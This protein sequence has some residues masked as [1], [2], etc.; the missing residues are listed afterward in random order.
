MGGAAEEIAQPVESRRFVLVGVATVA[1]MSVW[2]AWANVTADRL[3]Q[4]SAA[5]VS[6]PETIGPWSRSDE[7][8]MTSWKPRFVGADTSL[9]ATYQGEPGPVQMYLAYY[10]QQQQGSELVNSL[11]ADRKSVV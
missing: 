4:D 2:P 9:T 1:A 5:H 11:N 6:L 3:S 8:E 10:A 7:L